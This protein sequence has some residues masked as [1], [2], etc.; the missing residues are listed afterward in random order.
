VEFHDPGRVNPAASLEENL[1]FGRISL[2]EANAEPRVRAL[3]RR[4]LAE[5]GLEG[6][7]YRLGLDSPVDASGGGALSDGAVGP[8]DRIGIELVRCLA[9]SPDILV[10][11]VLEARQPEDF[12]TRLSGLRRAM[13]GRGLI[14]CLHGAEVPEGAG[15]FD[16]VVAVENSTVAAAPVAAPAP[17]LE[18]A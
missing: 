5:G 12:E 10:M 16:A 14:A 18:P 11:A 4:F 13:T 3:L 6:A 8:R 9:R 1:L 2:G 15:P 17:V 7:V